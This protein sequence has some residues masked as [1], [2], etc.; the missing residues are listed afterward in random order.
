M[1]A[2]VNTTF[3]MTPEEAASVSRIVSKIGRK[4]RTVRAPFDPEDYD[5]FA[6]HEDE[7]PNWNRDQIKSFGDF[8]GANLEGY[9]NF[10]PKSIDEAMKNPRLRHTIMMEPVAK[11]TPSSLAETTR[12]ETRR[13]QSNGFEPMVWGPYR[14]HHKTN[15]PKVQ[16]AVGYSTEG[17]KHLIGNILEAHLDLE[18]GTLKREQVKDPYDSFIPLWYDIVWQEQK[19]RFRVMCEKELRD[20]DTPSASAL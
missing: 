14:D 3:E 4:P 2:A 5:I 17:Y 11:G 18:P 6:S 12:V 10:T 16:L 7:G 1:F 8:R 20:I 15:Y 13:L 9:P 19:I